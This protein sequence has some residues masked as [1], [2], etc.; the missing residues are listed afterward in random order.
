MVHHGGGRVASL[1]NSLWGARLR[2]VE[3]KVLD[4]G[5]EEAIVRAQNV[6][7]RR[8]MSAVT[9]VRKLPSLRLMTM[10]AKRTEPI[11]S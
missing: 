4:A 5:T 7:N 11:I 3:H 1:W 2:I 10:E 6:I 9:E 8:H